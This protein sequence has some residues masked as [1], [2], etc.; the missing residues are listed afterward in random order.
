MS[1][2]LG[3]GSQPACL[4]TLSTYSDS[5]TSLSKKRMLIIQNANIA[6]KREVYNYYLSK[7]SPLSEAEGG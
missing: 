4:P 6:T 3:F 7:G 5:Q 1:K 2:M